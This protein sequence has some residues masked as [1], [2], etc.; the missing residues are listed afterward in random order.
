MRV[1]SAKRHLARFGAMLGAFVLL[2]GVSQGCASQPPLPAV[3]EQASPEAHVTLTNAAKRLLNG[4]SVTFANDA[5]TRSPRVSLAPAVRNTPNGRLAT[6]RTIRLPDEL[7]L[8]RVGRSC[9]LLH[10]N[11]DQRLGLPGVKCRAT[12][13]PL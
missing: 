13:D 7:R 5:F 2:A 9:E 10:V 8:V 12:G 3:L 4:R 1:N 11:T 6:G